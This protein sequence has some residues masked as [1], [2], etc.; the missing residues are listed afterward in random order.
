MTGEERI[1]LSAH[2]PKLIPVIINDI[3]AF[4]KVCIDD[5]LIKYA[6]KNCIQDMNFEGNLLSQNYP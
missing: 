3:Q 1:L 5:H 2:V 4:R 6:F